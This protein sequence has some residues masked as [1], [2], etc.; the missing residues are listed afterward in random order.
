VG[1]GA[2]RPVPSTVA[3]P[4]CWAPCCCWTKKTMARPVVVDAVCWLLLLA[5]TTPAGGS[6]RAADDDDDH[7]VRRHIGR[8]V[9]PPAFPDFVP[10][11][12]VWERNGTATHDP[13]YMMQPQP[14]A[15]NGDIGLC[16]DGPPEETTFH[17][18]TTSFWCSNVAPDSS[19]TVP[20]YRYEFFTHTRIGTLS[21][22]APSMEGG[23][24]SATQEL[25]AAR[26]NASFAREEQGHGSSDAALPSMHH[27]SIVTATDSVVLTRLTVRQRTPVVLTLRHPTS[28]V[29]GPNLLAEAGWSLQDEA[30]WMWRRS[31]V[32]VNNSLVG[33]NCFVGG[34][35]PASQLF[36]VDERTRAV[37]LQDGRCLQM[38]AAAADG[39]MSV[40]VGACSGGGAAAADWVLRPAAPPRPLPPPPPPP[41]LPPAVLRNFTAVAHTIGAQPPSSLY[42]CRAAAGLGCESEAAAM[43]MREHTCAG[44]AVCATWHNGTVA[45]LFTAAQVAKSAANE[46]WT[47]FKKKRAGDGGSSGGAS[48]ESGYYELAHVPTGMCVAVS[49]GLNTLPLQPC[50]ASS[51]RWSYNAS[52]LH[53]FEAGGVDSWGAAWEA[54]GARCVTAVEPNPLVAAGLAVQLRSANGSI[55]KHVMPLVNASDGSASIATTIE[56]G[57]YDVVTAL[58]TRGDCRGCRSDIV[59]VHEAALAAVRAATPSRL[60]VAHAE[61]WR[62]YWNASM[63][64]LGPRWRTLE[65]FYYGAGRPGRITLCF[66]SAVAAF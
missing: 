52:S 22:S 3:A 46:L 42:H 51:T 55:V 49:A 13:S 35:R 27:S 26:I 66:Q 36:V 65:S 33:A 58:E 24:Y 17:L 14:L 5:T 16:F 15:G 6:R 45:E 11:N 20:H 57:E 64:D 39:K 1:G 4:A 29:Y 62:R 40:T 43:C 53:V 9:A 56:A 48:T 37:T 32:Q 8:W 31:V 41:P 19:R 34:Q 54:G 7:P 25:H 28:W 10:Q 12:T 23:S 38:F 44:F 30:L 63:V 2:A 18:T 50:N 59:A 47:L 61:W 21:L 60:R